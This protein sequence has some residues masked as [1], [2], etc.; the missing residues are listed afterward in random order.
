MSHFCKSNV[1][2]Y[3]IVFEYYNC[4]TFGLETDFGEFA[5]PARDK[6]KVEELESAA[7]EAL[8]AAEKVMLA[9]LPR[10]FRMVDVDGNGTE[11]VL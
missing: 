3:S 8:A 2:L 6:G 5:A 4:V 11:R 10:A 9:M 1:E 7:A